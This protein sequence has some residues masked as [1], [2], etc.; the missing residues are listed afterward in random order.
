MARDPGRLT[1]AASP[2]SFPGEGTKLRGAFTFPS[3]WSHPGTAF[4]L[5]LVALEN[6]SSF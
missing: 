1:G 6:L 4:I 2:G 3:S 5:F